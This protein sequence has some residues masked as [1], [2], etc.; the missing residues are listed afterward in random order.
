MKYQGTTEEFQFSCYQIYS[1]PPIELPFSG[2]QTI[3]FTFLPGRV[4]LYFGVNSNGAG[5]VANSITLLPPVAVD[6]ICMDFCT[7]GTTPALKPIVTLVKE[8]N[9]IISKINLIAPSSL[10]GVPGP[11]QYL[12]MAKI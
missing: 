2:T 6:V 11:I 3:Y 1:I 9:G 5:F 10:T 12:V 7:S 8:N 4:L